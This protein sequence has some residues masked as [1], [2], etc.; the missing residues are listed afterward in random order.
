MKRVVFKISG[1]VFKENNLNISESKLY[2]VGQDIK[3]LY[4]N[5]LEIIVI[6]GAGNLW[7]GRFSKAM[8]EVNADNIGM[9]GTTMNSLALYDELTRINLPVKIYNSFLIEGMIDSYNISKCQEDLHNR[10]I[11]II[12]GGSRLPLCS[13]DFA[14]IQ[15]AVELDADTILLGKSV[16]GVYNKDVKKYDDAKKYDEISSLDILKEHISNGAKSL[17]ILDLTAESL[18]VKYNKDVFVFD[19]NDNKAI[20]EIIKGENPGTIIKYN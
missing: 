6:C 18:L 15:R 14:C 13:T 20:D 12:G 5:N 10:K 7:R 8:K 11:I 16:D 1:E 3:K 17:G 2:K 19:M 4:D 9:L